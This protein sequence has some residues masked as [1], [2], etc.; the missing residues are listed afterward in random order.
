[1]KILVVDDH[2]LIRDALR[3]VL[4][5]LKPRASILEARDC[6]EA[7]DILD[8]YPGLDLV[9]LDLILPDSDGFSMLV[10]LRRR[11]PTTAVV[12]LSASRDQS[13][14]KQALELGAVGFIPKT[15]DRDVMFN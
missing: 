13:K 7:M 11:C 15:T 5:K 2:V 6:R 1:M 12:V 14:I 4:N 3:G 9:L 10:E 8:Q